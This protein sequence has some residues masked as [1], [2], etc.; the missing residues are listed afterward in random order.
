VRF[1]AEAEGK[2]DS[3]MMFEIMGSKQEVSLFCSGRA[4]LPKV[5]G[6]SRIVFMKRIK[7]MTP[8]APLPSKKYVIQDNL[9]SFGPLLLFKKSEWRAEVPPD[10]SPDLLTQY[11]SVKTTNCE[12]FRL[13]NIGNYKCQVDL[14][15]IDIDSPPIFF[16]DPPVFTLDEGETK[17]VKVWAFPTSSSTFKNT[18]VCCVSDNPEPLLFDMICSGVVPTIEF[19]GPWEEARAAAIAAAEAAVA[20]CKDPKQLKDLEAK[21][22]AVIKGSN[23]FFFNLTIY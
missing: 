1:S 10:A 3:V 16:F 15:L 19:S 8:N 5:N 4:E 6:D 21:R 9:Y 23:L 12:I 17:E 18:L 7:N 2:F 14:G 13:T 22:D 20:E 11:N